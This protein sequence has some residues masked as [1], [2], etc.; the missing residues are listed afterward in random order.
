MQMYSQMYMIDCNVLPHLLECGLVRPVEQFDRCK[1]SDQ[2]QVVNFGFPH[3]GKQQSSSI[4][5]ALHGT[6]N[7]RPCAWFYKKGGCQNGADCRHCHMCPEGEHKIRK[8]AKHAAMHHGRSSPSPP[9]EIVNAANQA[10]H[11]NFEG[12]HDGQ[13]LDEANVNARNTFLAA[14]DENTTDTSTGS[15]TNTNASFSEDESSAA[16]IVSIHG[17][18]CP[19]EP[20]GL[21][22]SVIDVRTDEVTWALHSLLLSRLPADTI[23]IEKSIVEESRKVMILVNVYDGAMP[24]CYELIHE[25]KQQLFD[26]VAHSMVLGLVSARVQKETAYLG[27][28]LRSSVACIPE[29]KMD[30]VC[31]DAFRGCCRKRDCRCYHPQPDDMITL[32]VTIRCD[33]ERRN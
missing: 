1:H 8:K 3:R 28:S 4:G 19:C 17:D 23:K 14:Q 2:A 18:S 24:K 32:K 33:L 13:F 11:D 5:S 7:C 22:L 27:Y 26:L 16:S 9:I 25:I 10:Q 29:D 12:H 21:A 15:F 20:P 31:W 30:R 6:G